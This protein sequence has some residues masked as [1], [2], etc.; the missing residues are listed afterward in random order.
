ME[1]EVTPEAVEL[2]RRSLRLAGLGDR[3]EA[4]I[5]LRSAHGLGGGV[6]VQIELA[7]GPGG[8]EQTIE[9][10]GIKLFVAPEIEEAVPDPVV[11]VEPQHETVVVRPR[12]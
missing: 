3:G 5:R 12:S 9:A 4:G 6:E 2:L 1:I 11:T 8:D 10:G 7:E